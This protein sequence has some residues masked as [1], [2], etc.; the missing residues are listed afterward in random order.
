[1]DSLKKASQLKCSSV[2]FAAIGAGGLA[3]KATDCAEGTLSA[4]RKFS[5]E[6]T[7]QTSIQSVR[8]VMFKKEHI[9]PFE[10]AY[11]KSSVSMRIES[12]A[13][14]DQYDSQMPAEAILSRRVPSELAM[15]DEYE[16][17]LRP[18]TDEAASTDPVGE[19][20]QKRLARLPR[21]QQQLRFLP[22]EV[23]FKLTGPSKQV[24][25]ETQRKLTRRISMDLQ[26]EEFRDADLE[27]LSDAD[28]RD[29]EEAAIR[30]RVLIEYKSI[31]TFAMVGSNM[32][33]MSLRTFILSKAQA[34]RQNILHRASER[35]ISSAKE[36][37]RQAVAM[38]SKMKSRLEDAHASR[39]TKDDYPQ[40][41]TA[42]GRQEYNLADLKSSDAEYKEAVALFQKTCQRTVL[43]VQRVENP[44]LYYQFWS[45]LNLFQN[46]QACK[47][48]CT[49]KKLWH[50]TK[51]ETVDKILGAGFDRSYSGTANATAY[52]KGNYFASAASYSTG[53]SYAKPVP[54]TKTARVIL[55]H[56]AVLD[57]AKGASDLL[58]PPYRDPTAT[59]KGKVSVLVD[60]LE[61]PTMYITFSD[62]QA[63][64][65]YLLTYQI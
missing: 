8:L 58:A 65:A 51:H 59:E 23:F 56:V 9:E 52:G 2:A 10:I 40:T 20:R 11:Q 15:E 25:D 4:I 26:P 13:Q 24:V 27:V 50:G 34:A 1:M 37:E 43:S 48:D 17:L 21:K 64:P 19:L 62:G 47:E 33:R 14:Q 44:P 22:Q 30:H 63:Y 39:F 60:K 36:K 54:G 57:I 7:G 16:Q 28:E 31:D 35:Q 38:A 49:V 61:N 45:C 46:Q 41:W 55:A 6:S 42:K 5:T 3:F 12:T 32:D 18:V 53:G 29:I